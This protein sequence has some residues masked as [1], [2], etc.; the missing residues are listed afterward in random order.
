MSF[1]PLFILNTVIWGT[2]WLAIKYQIEVVSPIWSVVYRFGLASLLLLVFCLLTRRNLSYSRVAH[3]IMALQG[4]FLFCLNYILYYLGTS[5]LISG[6]V[7]LIGACTIFFN[8]INSYLF[9]KMPI[10]IRVVVGASIGFLGLAV[11]FSNEIGKMYQATAGLRGIIIGIMC[12]VLGA[13]I[14]SFGN[15]TAVKLH[16]MQIPL[17]QGAAI[18]MIYGTLYS[19]V[20]ALLFQQPLQFSFSPSYLISLFYLT[21]FGTII[22]FGCYLTL[23]HNVGPARAGYISIITPLVA[24]LISTFFESFSWNY[25]TVIGMMLIIG[26]NVLVLTKRN[27]SVK[28]SFQPK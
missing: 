7:A 20:I 22:A 2:T 3:S 28:A 24:I 18:S 19:T 6:L 21:I 1:I 27:P 17:L 12:C 11:V 4:L 23:L 25:V 16:R 8:I 5:Y 15:M 10:M 13:L 9:F 14:A 26:G